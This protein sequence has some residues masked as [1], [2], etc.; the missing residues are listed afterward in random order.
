[1]GNFTRLPVERRHR[2]C[3]LIFFAMT[4]SI[5]L[6]KKNPRLRS[7]TDF[8]LGK[9]KFLLA[10]TGFLCSK[11]NNEYVHELHKR[12][13][14]QNLDTNVFCFL[15]ISLRCQNIQRLHHYPTET[16]VF[17]EIRTTFFNII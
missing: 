8:E 10:L 16:Y 9:L 1:M 2:E 4:E 5:S 13:V 7:D 12:S 14:T 15:C 17:L 11:V 3:E 6:K